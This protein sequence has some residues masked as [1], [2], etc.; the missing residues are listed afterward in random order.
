MRRQRSTP[1]CV[2]CRFP[3]VALHYRYEP[4]TALGLIRRLCHD[5]GM[6]HIER[7]LPARV[8]PRSLL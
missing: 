8:P 5:Y 4:L 6:V 1:G 2:D 7:D 3:C